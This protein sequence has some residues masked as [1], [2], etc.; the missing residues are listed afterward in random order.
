V[1][2]RVPPPAITYDEKA[3]LPFCLFLPYS[4]LVLRILG[5]WRFATACDICAA[6]LMY[7]S[8]VKLDWCRIR[9]CNASRV[10]LAA[11]IVANARRRSW[12]PYRWQ[13]LVQT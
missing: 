4:Y 7:R 6:K 12:K 11:F 8:V 1:W 5:T 3:S 10:M 13:A 9:C 2:V